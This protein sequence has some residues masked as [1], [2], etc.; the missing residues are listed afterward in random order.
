MNQPGV[1]IPEQQENTLTAGNEIPSYP[2]E[3]EAYVPEAPY[4]P[5]MVERPIAPVVE[6][7]RTPSSQELYN[8][9]ERQHIPESKMPELQTQLRPETTRS[10]E[11]IFVNPELGQSTFKGGVSSSQLVSRVA[12]YYTVQQGLISDPKS[13]LLQ[14]TATTGDPASASTWQATI[15]YKILQAFWNILGINS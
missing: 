1:T 6:Q 4:V 8:A 13:G 15:L 10:G 11:K 5:P 3:P 7:Q 2:I 14:Q 9:P 12:G